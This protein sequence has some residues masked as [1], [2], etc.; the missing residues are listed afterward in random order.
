M[1]VLFCVILGR[2]KYQ[3]RKAKAKKKYIYIK[4]KDQK[5]KEK[6]RQLRC[7]GKMS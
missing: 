7:S 3:T 1:I 4:R 2:E 6:R 5:E